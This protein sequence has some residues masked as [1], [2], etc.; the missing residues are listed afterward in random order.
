MGRKSHEV[1]QGENSGIGGLGSLPEAGD[2]YFYVV[3]I[4][5]YLYLFTIMI[6]FIHQ[7]VVVIII[8]LNKLN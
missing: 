6:I 4:M 2:F 3:I 7:Q 8:E 5:I 1:V